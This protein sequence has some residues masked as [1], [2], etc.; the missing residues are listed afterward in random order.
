MYVKE[1]IPLVDSPELTRM[2]FTK[3][4]LSTILK[5]QFSSILHSISKLLVF[6]TDKEDKNYY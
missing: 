2:L 5:W 3:V 6:M 4:T 1:L